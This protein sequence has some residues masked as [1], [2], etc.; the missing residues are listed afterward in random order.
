[1]NLHAINLPQL[2]GQRRVDGVGR[3]K[4]DFHTVSSVTKPTMYEGDE[5]C[6]GDMQSLSTIDDFRGCPSTS[7]RWPRPRLK[8]RRTSSRFASAAWEGSRRWRAVDATRLSLRR[9]RAGG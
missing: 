7:A 3:P 5:L 9:W 1:M 2:F 8:M 4:F 6:S